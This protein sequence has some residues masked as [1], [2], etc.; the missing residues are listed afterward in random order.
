[1]L[2]QTWIPMSFFLSF[3]L[4]LSLYFSLISWS[5][6]AC[7]IT[8]RILPSFLL[9][10][11]HCQLQTTRSGPLKD[12]HSPSTNPHSF[13]PQSVYPVSSPYPLLPLDPNSVTSA[14]DLTGFLTHLPTSK[15]AILIEILDRTGRVIHLNHAWVF[16]SLLLHG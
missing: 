2:H 13:Y 14:L 8:R 15:A 1:M 6:E 16:H 7:C 10:L 9:S 11:L 3:S 4:S 12:K 5:M